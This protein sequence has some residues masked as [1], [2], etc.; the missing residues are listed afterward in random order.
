MGAV[1]L[2]GGEQLFGADDAQLDAEL[3]ADQLLA[4]F[5]AVRGRVGLGVP[6]GR[7]AI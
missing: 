7:V 4:P 5:P 6:D 3:G 1:Q 2:A